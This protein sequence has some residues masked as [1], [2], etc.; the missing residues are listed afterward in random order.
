MQVEA[1]PSHLANVIQL[2]VYQFCRA[3]RKI[4]LLAPD[5]ARVLCGSPRQAC[6]NVPHCSR[7]PAHVDEL[8]LGGS[9]ELA[10]DRL[11]VI[12]CQ[13]LD[14]IGERQK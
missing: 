12:R 8:D 5:R 4:I 11:Y 13:L 10:V 14:V 3:E 2:L 9:H 1:Y 7:A 6:V